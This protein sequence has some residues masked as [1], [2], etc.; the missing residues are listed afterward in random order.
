MPT[1][2]ALAFGFSLVLSAAILCTSW[3]YVTRYKAAEQKALARHAEDQSDT[4]ERYELRD[5]RHGTIAGLAL[6][7]KRIGR[8]WLLTAMMDKG[9]KSRDTFH[10]V[11]VDQLWETYETISNTFEIGYALARSDQE[12]ER[13]SKRQF[14]EEL[15]R[16]Q[17][18]KMRTRPKLVTNTDQQIASEEIL[19]KDMARKDA[20][21][22]GKKK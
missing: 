22:I 7:D 19:I 3:L 18:L 12:R 9:K 21:M 13:L 16:W 2:A 20:Q 8:V 6:L 17:D 14:G 5:Y 1:R 15:P 11:D 4:A 10:E